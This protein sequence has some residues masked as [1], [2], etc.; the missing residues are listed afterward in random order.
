MAGCGDL[1]GE[2]FMAGKTIRKKPVEV[3]SP[4]QEPEIDMAKAG[5]VLQET[6]TIVNNTVKH[7]WLSQSDAENDMAECFKL[8]AALLKTCP[9]MTVRIVGS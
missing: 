3:S 7:Y 4:Q 8:L 5:R 2:V 9:Q 1:H 6:A